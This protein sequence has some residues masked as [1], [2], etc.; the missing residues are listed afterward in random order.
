[1]KP[2][3]DAA[4]AR[5]REAVERPDVSGTRYEILELIGR[6]GMGAVY[7]ARDRELDR[8]LALKVAS[9]PEADSDAAVRLLREARIIARLEHPGIVPVHDVGVLPDGRAFYAMK[10][11]S[12]NR[13]DRIAS[14]RPP[15]PTLLRVFVRICEA[16][17]FAH[18]H[19]VVHRDLKPDNVM[20]GAFGEVLVMDWG[21]A[22][23]PTAGAGERA[24]ASSGAGRAEGTGDGAVLGTPGYM[25]P[26]Q[27]RGDAAAADAR[28]DVYS[29]GAILH[30]LLHGCPQPREAVPGDVGAPRPLAA[31]VLKA[32]AVEPQDRYA[33][34]GRLAADVSRFLDG[35]PVSAYRE[36]PLERA[37][38][39]ARKYRTPL[40]LVLAYLAMRTVL[41]LVGGR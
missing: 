38:R 17:A 36:G 3:S 9:A 27:A 22:K 24:A 6:G 30:F 34:V 32:L 39:L 11:V 41:I 31:V 15:L 23:W 19:G 35:E 18:A 7:L 16:V 12:G 1:V 20:V 5:L 14:E 25:A 40:L 8:E 29:L 21:V 13:L 37:A 33:D 2:L 10:L 28:A 26:E 4:L